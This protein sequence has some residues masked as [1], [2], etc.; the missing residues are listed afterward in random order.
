MTDEVPPPPPPPP[1]RKGG[2]LPIGDLNRGLTLSKRGL[3]AAQMEKIIEHTAEAV[4]ERLQEVLP[5]HALFAPPRKRRTQE[6]VAADEAKKQKERRERIAARKAKAAA[7]RSG[8]ETADGLPAYIPGAKVHGRQL[9]DLRH[10]TY[11]S[12]HNMLMRCYNPKHVSY[13]EYG[14]RG[15]QVFVGWIPKNMKLIERVADKEG[16]AENYEQAYARFV[17]DVG[18]KPTPQHTLDRIKAAGHYVPSNVR[19]ATPEEQGINKRFTHHI[20]HPV[21]GLKVPAATVAKEAGISYQLLRARMVKAGTWYK[22]NEELNA[23]LGL[24]SAHGVL[25]PG[26]S[27]DTSPDTSPDVQSIGTLDDDDAEHEP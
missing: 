6:E 11:T 8:S 23:S 20:Y 25:E 12:W 15:I 4:V 2:P 7:Q 13:S 5:A 18:L 16:M 26:A 19:W 27:P 10:R 9:A 14:G 17:G 1:Q 22:V 21:T 3:P 24:S